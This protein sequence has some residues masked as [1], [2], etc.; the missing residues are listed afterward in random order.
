MDKKL[1]AVFEEHGF[2][3][4]FEGRAD[5]SASDLNMYKCFSENPYE[6]LF[7]F[8]FKPVYDVTAGVKFLHEISERMIDKFSHKADIEFTRENTVFEFS[9]D[10]LSNLLLSVPFATGVEY[11]N[12]FWLTEIFNHLGD[13]FRSI[14]AKYAGTVQEFL[15]EQK[16]DL[17]VMGRV[18]FHLVENKNDE[19]PFAFLATYSVQSENKKVNHV[20]LKSALLEYKGQTSKLLELLSTVSRV[21]QKSGLISRLVESGELFSPLRF[22]VDEAY[23]FLKELSLYEESGIICRIPDWWKK[24][25]NKIGISINL[26][27]KGESRVGEKAILSFDSRFSLGDEFLSEAE[28]NFLLSQTEG[29]VF[30]KGKWVEVNHNRLKQALE[31]MEKAKAYASDGFVSIFDAMRFE[32]DAQKVLGD[33]SS[34]VVQVTNGV[35]FENALNKIR[36]PEN[37]CDVGAGDGFMAILRSYQQV[38]L[39][40][41][42]TMIDMGFG[43]C[44]ADDMGLGKTVQIIGLLEY[45]R[46][47]Q[48]QEK[49]SLLVIPASL[50]GNWELELRRFAPF[51][52]Y[53]VLHGS[54]VDVSLSNDVNLYIT[55]YAMLY[56]LSDVLKVDWNLLIL[57]EAQAI[58]NSGTKQA[59]AVKSVNAKSRI[60]LTGTPVENRLGDLWSLFDFLNAGLLGS[61]KEFKAFT[62]RLR[63]HECDYGKLRFVVS[64]FILRRLKTDKL[65]ISDLPDKVEM[66]R[67]TQLSKKQVVLYQKFVNDLEDKLYNSEGIDRKGLILAS[68]LRL[69][70]ICNHPDHYLGQMEYDEKYSGKFMA[71]R[72]ICETV[73]EKRERV[74]VFTQFRE[75]IEPLNDFLETI[76]ERKGLVLHGGIQVSKRQAIVEKFCGREYVPYMILSLKAG[77]VGLNLVAANHVIH[78]DRWWNPAVENQATD[79]A[80]R[81]GQKKNVVV[82]KFITVNTI[83]EKIDLMIEDKIRLSSDIVAATGE[84]WI[85]EMSNDEL[86]KLFR[87]AGEK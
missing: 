13:V 16:S 76:F 22:S 2:V 74:L 35:W 7:L 59:K 47:S 71:L 9:D 31:I 43:A 36:K 58:K 70:Q 66:K 84:N 63:E 44:L 20:P 33:D 87:M 54:R 23:T 41:L 83:E 85:T 46:V 27:D 4:D 62:N 24:S 8:G 28:L 64:P 57:D 19:M 79:R 68:L 38:G 67:Y 29:L 32:M 5:A 53:S 40:W 51:L 52:K 6:A 17:T 39:N 86:M 21:V 45:L 49:P 50:I 61:A 78:F 11:V 73:Y 77:G 75:I 1:I 69:K 34:G 3:L 15:V 48:K 37:I 25:Q 14:I 60:A 10:E 80:F 81:I 18:F 72:E 55:T 82:H 65:I 42:V 12:K 26:G 30:L 56:R